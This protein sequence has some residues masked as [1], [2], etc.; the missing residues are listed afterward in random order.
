MS[1][2]CSERR[3][4]NDGTGIKG[5]PCFTISTMWFTF[6]MYVMP[7]YTLISFCACIIYPARNLSEIQFKNSMLM[8]LLQRHV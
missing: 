8:A 6:Y 4:A 7:E 2:F 5:K 3:P 1:S